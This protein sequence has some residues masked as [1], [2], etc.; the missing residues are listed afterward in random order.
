M[1]RCSRFRVRDIVER[2][3]LCEE[4]KGSQE[5]GGWNGARMRRWEAS[6]RKR[7]GSMSCKE[8]EFGNQIDTMPLP[9]CVTF[10]PQLLL[11]ASF[12]KW[13]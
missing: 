6:G 8:W 13:G 3:G 11:G 7:Y 2:G 1:E 12:G 9:V 10:R 5:K 4:D